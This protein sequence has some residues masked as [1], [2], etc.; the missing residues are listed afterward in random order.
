MF[1]PWELGWLSYSEIVLLLFL[2]NLIQY[3]Q[4]PW[5]SL[6]NG[7]VD[8]TFNLHSL[9]V[10]F[11]GVFILYTAVKEI[12]HMVY[13]EEHEAE[14]QKERSVNQVIAVIVFMNLIFLF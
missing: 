1:E 8:G 11:G 4:D 7:V 14:M 10:L 6:D 12:W 5:F 2:V 3:V 9:I 13:L